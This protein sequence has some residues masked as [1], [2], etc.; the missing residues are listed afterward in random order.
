MSPQWEEVELTDDIRL[1][2][3]IKNVLK[4]IDVP[5]EIDVALF[6]GSSRL[7]EGNPRGANSP[8]IE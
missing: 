7:L 8:L 4:G 3:A 6:W 2:S 1:I 5:L